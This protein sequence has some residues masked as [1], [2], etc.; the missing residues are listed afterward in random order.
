LDRSP[1]EI[2]QALLRQL[3]TASDDGDG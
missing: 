1:K 3:A 2:Y